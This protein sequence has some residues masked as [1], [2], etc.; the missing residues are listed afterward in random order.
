LGGKLN[1]TKRIT[2]LLDATRNVGLKINRENSVC[3]RI[4]ST[5][6][7]TKYQCIYKNAVWWIFLLIQ[8]VTN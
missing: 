1:K 8:I 3:I 7:R 6:C 4:W 2:S 5:E